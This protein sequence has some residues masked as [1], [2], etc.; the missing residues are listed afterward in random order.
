MSTFMHI[1]DL[2]KESLRKS[3]LRGEFDDDNHM[4]CTARL[5]DMLNQYT[6][7]LHKDTLSTFGG[8]IEKL[9]EETPSVAVKRAK[10][11]KSIE[12]FRESKEVVAN[13]MDKFLAMVVRVQSLP[14][15]MFVCC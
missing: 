5:V 4:H 3:L 10:L 7:D 1:I 8:G 2:A 15:F 9:L 11:S 12:V 6:N 14:F 13:I